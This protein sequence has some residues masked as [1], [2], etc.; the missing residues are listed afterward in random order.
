MRKYIDNILLMVQMLTR[1]PVKRALPCEKEDFKRGAGFIFIIGLIIG[2][3]QYLLYLLLR[4][5]MSSYMLS[6]LI[7]LVDI[8]FTG[9]FHIDGFGDTCDGFFAAKG[10]DKIIEIMKDSRIGTFACIGIMMNILIKLFGYNHI[11]N[12]G[13]MSLL[14][15]GIPVLGRASILLMCYIGRPAKSGGLGGLFINNVYLLQVIINVLIGG[16]IIAVALGIYGAAL[17]LAAVLA[18]D[19]LFNGLCNSKINGIT[20][21]S[22]GA[23]NELTVLVLLIIATA[24]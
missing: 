8:F 22:L 20:G 10:K 3:V 19:M 16:A 18:V 1:I 12:A 13:Y 6:I 17:M 4:D 21:D 14:V 2:G 24:F 9:G 23:A 15:L 11:I 7:I 5:R